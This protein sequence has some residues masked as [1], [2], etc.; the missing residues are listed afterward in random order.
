MQS[1]FANLED[2]GE[3]FVT[4]ATREIAG[5]LVGVLTRVHLAW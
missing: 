5:R 1:T 3:D 4:E 2:G